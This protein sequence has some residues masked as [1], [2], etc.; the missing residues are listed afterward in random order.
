[1][2]VVIV[3]SVCSLEIRRSSRKFSR[4]TRFVMGSL[5]SRIGAFHSNHA[6]NPFSQLSASVMDMSLVRGPFG[7]SVLSRRSGLGG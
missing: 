6:V 1:M 4:R 2:F 3:V 7:F 5:V